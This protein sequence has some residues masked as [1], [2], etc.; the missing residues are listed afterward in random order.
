[1]WQQVICMLFGE[2]ALINLSIFLPSGFETLTYYKG[3][4]SIMVKI[5]NISSS[6]LSLFLYFKFFF[7]PLKR[8]ICHYLL[9][10]NV[11]Y[12]HLTHVLPSL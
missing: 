1:M 4:E 10:F 11:F 9:Y 3:G 7:K 6:S 8:D 5:L 12:V 2:L